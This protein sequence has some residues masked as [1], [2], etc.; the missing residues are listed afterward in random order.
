M[1]FASAICRLGYHG[2]EQLLAN[3]AS[4]NSDHFGTIFC[5][6]RACAMV[7]LDGQSSHSSSGLTFAQFQLQ[8]FLKDFRKFQS[9]APLVAFEIANA[10]QTWPSDI[11]SPKF[12]TI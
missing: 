2:I 10:A 11:P 4:A 8:G 5:L 6:L 1:V 3:P 7:R 9:I 12:R